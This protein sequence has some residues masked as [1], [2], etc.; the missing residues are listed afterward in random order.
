MD[1]KNVESFMHDYAKNILKRK[2]LG[3]FVELFLER[4]V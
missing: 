3:T 2:G 1:M 4:R